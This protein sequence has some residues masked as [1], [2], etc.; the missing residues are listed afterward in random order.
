[1][2]RAHS[3]L[4]RAAAGAVACGFFLAQPLVVLANVEELTLNNVPADTKVTIIGE[5][6]SDRAEARTKARDGDGKLVFQLKDRNWP[7]GKYILNIYE[8]AGAPVSELITLGD[9][10]NQIDVSTILG[11]PAAETANDAAKGT[12]P[13]RALLGGLAGTT[14]AGIVLGG[15]GGEL[16]VERRQEE[17]GGGEERRGRGGSGAAAGVAI[18][19]ALLGALASSL[20]GG[21]SSAPPAE[22]A[23]AT[24]PSSTAAPAPEFV[25][26]RV[27]A[28]IP[29]ADPPAMQALAQAIAGDHNLA[30]NAVNALESVNLGLVEYTILDGL[31]PAAKSAELAA[32]ARVESSQ[33]EFI[34]Q[35]TSKQDQLYYGPKLIRAANLP[36]NISGKGVR[37]ALIDTGVDGARPE[38]KGK[39]LESVDMTGKGLSGDV[40]GTM[41][42]GIIAADRDS[43]IGVAPN[44]ILLAVKACQPDRPQRMEGTCWSSALTRGIDFANTKAA[45]VINLSVGGPQ[46]G[47]VA[48]VIG[49]SVKRNITVVA[50]AGNDGPKGRPRY[51]AALDNV[52]AVTAVD[53]SRRLYREATRGK[54]IDV[55]APGVEIVSIGPGSRMPISSGT[56]F[57]AAF[58]TG[59]IALLL[60]QRG[61]FSP[62]TLQAALEKSAQ[63]LG[64]P[65]KDEEF[66]SGLVDACQVMAHLEQPGPCR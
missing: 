66:G 52:L 38:L 37:V 16:R 45:K 58:V 7:S 9:G 42:A 8:P 21:S 35:T 13:N 28:T 36:S 15:R 39:I 54:F 50:A 5:D 12:E 27:L 63:D 26:D 57:A 65:G 49:E 43:G 44:V 24:T 11:E 17:Y 18:G 32:D 61:D 53:S 46:D 60:E 22:P 47:L 10:A 48:R 1:M 6:R 25:A 14:G 56:S 41:L 64:T 34:Y 23:A 59:T 30:L 29:L 19:S 3:K 55:S 31:D 62:Q 40:H 4:F 33:P 51:P 20:F 2:P